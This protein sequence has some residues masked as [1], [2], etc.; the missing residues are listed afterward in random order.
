MF[1]FGKKKKDQPKLLQPKK[2]SSLDKILMG[3]V[4]GSAIGSVLGVGL[5]PKKGADT[6]KDIGKQANKIFKGA[7]DVVNDTTK[8]LLPVKKEN[9]PE[10][11]SPVSAKNIATKRLPEE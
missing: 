2:Q 6:R 5:A 9:K 11:R 4:L 1:G 10:T 3:V 7:K 8:K